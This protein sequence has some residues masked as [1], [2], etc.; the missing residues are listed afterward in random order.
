MKKIL[1]AF[2][3]IL[4]TS[5]SLLDTPSE[6]TTVCRYQEDPWDIEYI[7]VS[8]NDELIEEDTVQEYTWLGYMSEQDIMDELKSLEDL[9][10]G[11]SGI[12]YTYDL[13]EEQVIETFHIDYEQAS[14]DDLI[15][16]G[17]LE[18]SDDSQVYVSLQATLDNLEPLGFDC[19]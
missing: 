18:E 13:Q 10:A 2:L 7:F 1:L 8:Q 11:R 15:E 14:I 17:L 16:V 6:I 19:K 4:L 9:Y 3:L 5:C 12:S